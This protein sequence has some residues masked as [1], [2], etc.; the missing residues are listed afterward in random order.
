[1]AK[2]AGTKNSNLP[3]PPGIGTIITAVQNNKTVSPAPKPKCAV[4]EKA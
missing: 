1:M 4:P 3:T 2:T